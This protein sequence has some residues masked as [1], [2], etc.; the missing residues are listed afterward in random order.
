MIDETQ[1][2]MISREVMKGRKALGIRLKEETKGP[3]ID[4][5]VFGDRQSFGPVPY[6]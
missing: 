2:P 6:P 4:G 1:I 5:E 3:I